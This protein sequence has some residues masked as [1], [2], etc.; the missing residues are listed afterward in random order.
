MKITFDSLIRYCFDECSNKEE[1]LIEKAMFK[2]ALLFD[3]IRGIFLKKKALQ[4]K[5]EVEKFFEKKSN[6]FELKGIG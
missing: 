5:E 3:A 1:E 4:S 6:T 2:D